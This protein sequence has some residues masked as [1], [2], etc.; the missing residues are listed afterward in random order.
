MRIALRNLINLLLLAAWVLP[1]AALGQLDAVPVDPPDTPAPFVVDAV[2]ILG[3]RRVDEDAIRVRLEVGAGSLFDEAAID[4][5]I[6]SLYSMGFFR[7][8]TATLDDRVG[9]KVLT[10]QV[11]ERPFVRDVVVLGNEEID[12]EEIQGMVRIRPNTILDPQKARAGSDE[13]KKAYEKKGYLDAVISYDTTAVG[14]ADEVVV[15]Y[16]IVENEPVRIERI[17]LE[18]NEGSATAP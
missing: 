8:I 18:G 3:N 15:T 4:E 13:I 7:N 6:R 1:G 2:E 14:E 10:Y 5:D 17:V 16:R 9:Q 12:E 11:E